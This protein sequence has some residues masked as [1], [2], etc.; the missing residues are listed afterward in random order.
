VATVV[1][2]PLNEREE[3]ALRDLLQRGPER[4]VLL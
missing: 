2:R 3:A 1:P 4:D